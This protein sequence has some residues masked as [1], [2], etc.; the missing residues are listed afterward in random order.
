MDSDAL[1]RLKIM[2][3]RKLVLSVLNKVG[4]PVENHKDYMEAAMSDFDNA[5]ISYSLLAKELKI[6]H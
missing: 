3:L 2:K 6:E 4:E 1:D 5:L